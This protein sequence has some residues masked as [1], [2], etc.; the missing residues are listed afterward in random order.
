MTPIARIFSNATVLGTLSLGALGNLIEFTI[1]NSMHNRWA[2][3]NGASLPNPNTGDLKQRGTF[4]FDPMWDD[5][6]YDYLGE[7]YSSHVN[8]L[9]WRLHG[10]VNDRIED[11]FN[12]H[13]SMQ[14]GEIQRRDYNGVSW[15]KPGKWVQVEKPFYWPEEMHHHFHD[16]HNKNNDNEQKI[17][18]NILK[19]MDIIKASRNAFAIPASE[20]SEATMKITR[21]KSTSIP[22]GFNELYSYYY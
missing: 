9:F 13:E 16:L 8:P 6:K 2:N 10:W 18:E 21:A 1:H 3:D 20:L 19:V 12:A 11:W 4:D 15:F 17:V 7:F 22:G 14:P 5:P